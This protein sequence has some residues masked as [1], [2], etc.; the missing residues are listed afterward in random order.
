MK[1]KK[2]L[3]SVWDMCK[4]GHCVHFDLEHGS[5]AKHNQTGSVVPFTLNGKTW[6]MELDLIPFSETDSIMKK[7][8]E[9]NTKIEQLNPLGEGQVIFP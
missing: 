4:A 8:R 6:D 3:V 2:M 1:V 9:E 7:I 5:Y